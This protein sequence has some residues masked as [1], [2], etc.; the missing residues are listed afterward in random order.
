MNANRSDTE[1]ES[2][3]Q[4]PCIPLSLSLSAEKAVINKCTLMILPLPAKSNVQSPKC[5]HGSVAPHLSISS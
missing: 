3:S 5:N 2:Q 1:I 4:S